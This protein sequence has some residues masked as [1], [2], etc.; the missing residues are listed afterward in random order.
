MD[1][2][3]LLHDPEAER[4]A[5]F[6]RGWL[7][8]GM[9]VE[10]GI[11]GEMLPL[12]HE[13]APG[14]PD[15]DRAAA[16]HYDVFGLNVLPRA[17]FFLEADGKLSK[18]AR[19]RLLSRYIRGGYWPP[20]I[21]LADA[22][23]VQMLFLGGLCRTKAEA[24]EAQDWDAV[25]RLALIEG[26]FLR[27]QLLPWIAPFCEALSRQEDAHYAAVADLILGLTSEHASALAL[28]AEVE[29]LPPAPNLLADPETRLDDIAA[30]LA[31][32]ALA[33][34]LLDRRTL[35]RITRS[36]DL[37]TPFA[38]RRTMIADLLRAAGEYGALPAL[39]EALDGCAQDALRAYAEMASDL[40]PLAPWVTPWQARC[41]ESRTF[42]ADLRAGLRLLER[43]EV[44]AVPGVQP[45]AVGP[46]LGEE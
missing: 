4:W 46:P 32:P 36:L 1:G 43:I 35:R 22:L 30:R 5:R 15:A 40:A 41:A 28:Q 19:D 7:H 8:L 29:P 45:D 9:V 2:Y 39:T 17:G 38:D 10:R 21:D 16:Q 13:S 14:P 42:L 31:T 37:P 11:T 23:S 33:G 26:L 6:G 27:E 12:L 25:A 20:D 34:F 18:D 24:W 3:P 44:D